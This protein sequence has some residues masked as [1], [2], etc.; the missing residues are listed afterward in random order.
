MAKIATAF[1]WMASTGLKI[2][3]MTVKV[4]MTAVMVPT[5]LLAKAL[6]KTKMLVLMA[7]VADCYFFGCFD[8]RK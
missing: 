5:V 6:T 4:T 7:V 1:D 3:M 8:S 2:A